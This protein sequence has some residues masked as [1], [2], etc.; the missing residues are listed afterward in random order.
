MDLS[1]FHAAI[2]LI[3]V[4]SLLA[5]LPV[6][7]QSPASA[8]LP[9]Q[10]DF[11]AAVAL[12]QARHQHIVV[13]LAATD[14]ESC[15][16]LETKALAAPLIREGLAD[17]VWVRVENDAALEEQLGTKDRPTLVFVNPFTGGV[18][19]RVIGEKSVD[20][21][22]REI[23][24][25]RRAIGAALTPA[26]EDVAKRMFALD[27]ER[28][29]KLVEAGDASG[30]R[31]LLVPS[32]TDDSR[33]A[34]YLVV[35]VRLPVG[36]V[37]D[38]VRF[39]AGTDCLVGDDTTV[40]V[41]APAL[42]GGRPPELASSCTEY[43]IPA[44]GLVLVPC[45]RT[46]RA[47]VVIRITA[48]G[49]RLVSDTIRFDGPAPGTAV[50]VRH[51]DLRPLD[52]TAAATLSGRVFKPDGAPAAAAIV[53]IDDWFAAAAADGGSPVPVVVRTDTAGRFTFPRVSPGR[54]LVRAESPG[55]EREQFVVLE[56]AGHASCDL[57]LTAV[58]TV[59][60]RWVLQTR[61]HVQDLTGAGTQTGEA[62]FS[63]SSSRLAL[64]RGM[65]LRTGEACDLLLA[66]TPLDDDSLSEATQA[67][68]ATLPAGTPVWYLVDTAYTADLLPLS[69]L[70]RDPRPFAEID[71]VREET[72]LPEEDWAVIGPLLPEALTAAQNRGNYFQFARGEPVR[73]GD[74]F[75]LRCVTS[76]RFAK[77]EVTDVTIVRPASR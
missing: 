51:Y 42:V 21:L 70:H 50:Q 73:K 58:T 12:A 66:Q 39:L 48:P 38:D 76:N 45:E 35:S 34:N 68:L 29:E 31:D 43:G 54:W 26:F 19:H 7:A 59:G 47:E 23:V 56:P 69:G 22:A 72:P 13:L 40:D 60:L 9:W 1:R 5:T 2:R 15:R 63:V 61:E 28:A 53:R 64:A 49:C 11:A 33:Q 10:P 18:L 8:P 3:L 17:M 37:P 25:A 74:V 27:G 65:R 71:T 55:G 20:I 32:A 6:V 24:H 14:C 62:Y 75:T 16:R 46:E 36:M 44:S 67:S 41:A 52:D 57:P 77:L 4:A 30:L